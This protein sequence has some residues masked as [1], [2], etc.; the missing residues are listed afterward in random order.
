[1]SGAAQTPRQ[2]AYTAQTDSF[3]RDRLPAANQMP[4]LRFDTPELQFPEC[5]NLVEA[6]F[7]RAHAFGHSERPFLR[8]SRITFSYAEAHE[9]VNRIAALLVAAAPYRPRVSR[10]NE[11]HRQPATSAF[12]NFL[13][14]VAR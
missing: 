8:S 2:P 12:A 5:V 6:L 9:R 10:R 13:L 14:V 11:N 4:L 3:V 1:M 7:A